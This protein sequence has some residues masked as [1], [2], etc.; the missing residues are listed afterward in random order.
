MIPVRCFTCNNLIADKWSRFL[1]QK[2]GSGEYGVT[3]D[4]IGLT[5]FC[6]RRMFLTHVDVIDDIIQYSQMDEIVDDSG[7]VFLCEV[8]GYRVIPCD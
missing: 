3:L 8:N 6:C 7:T 5:R 1:C 2:D 4:N